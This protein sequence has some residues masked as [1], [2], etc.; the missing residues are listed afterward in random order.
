MSVFALKVLAMASMVCDHVGWY[1]NMQGL[2]SSPVCTAMRSFGRLA[3]PIFAFLIVN[4]CSHTKDKKGYITRLMLFALISQPAYTAVFTAVN[5]SAESGAVSFQLPGT[6]QMLLCLLLGLIW[7]RCIRRG[8]SAII[9]ALAPFI[10]LCTLKLGGLYLLRP[11]MNV[12]YTLGF[13][14]A[15]ICVLELLQDKSH[16]TDLMAAVAALMIAL[17][18]LWTRGDYGFSGILLI[19]MLWYFRDMQMQ[20][21]IMLPVWAA[22]HY[23]PGG[24]TLFFICAALALLPVSMYKG[25]L[26]KPLKTVFYLVYP[27]HLSVLAL[28]LIWQAR[29]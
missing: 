15:A 13:S 9:I 22:A 27:L 6:L 29:L 17:L 18:L 11:H 16:K 14:L 7:H 3:F 23:L 2:I 25:R 5:Y 1:L 4:G 10:G 24:N 28:M 20:Q 21:Y 8:S 12:F 26:G 19:L